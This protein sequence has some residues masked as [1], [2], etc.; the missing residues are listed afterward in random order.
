MKH[1]TASLIAT[2]LMALWSAL[3][4]GAPLTLQECLK[5]AREA[6]PTLRSGAWD[7]RKAQQVIRQ[8]AAAEYPRI[9]AQL[10]YTMQL[11]PQAVKIGGFTAETQEPDFAFGGVAASYT[12][13]DFGRRAARTNGARASAEA[14]SQQYLA[15]RDDIALQ[16]IEAYYR[17]LE[18]EQLVVAAG[19]EVTRIEEHRRITQVLYEEGVVTRNDVLQA[20]VRLA[21]ARQRRLSA[22]NVRDNA[23][24][25]L[26]FLTGS[27]AERR[28]EL[29]DQS[30][31]AL[32]PPENAEI[33]AD[34]GARHDLQALRHTLQVR[35]FEVSENREN[36][37]PE[38]YTRLALEYVQN[39]NVREQAIM[40]ATI[41]FR[42]NLFDGYAADA[43]RAGALLARSRQQDIIR[44]AELQA[45]LEVDTARNDLAVAR[46]QI[47]VAERAIQQ[48]EENLRINRERYRERV[49]TASEVL[50]AQTLLTQARTDFY[51]ARYAFQTA[52]A[53]LQRAAG[54]L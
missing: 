20:D 50:D 7:I 27:P 18:S 24:L 54:T 16:V 45:R 19:D 13:Y 28:A 1:L 23:W 8:T 2:M 40:S 49:G 26:N 12:F 47:V 10:G 14:V 15:R 43:A 3:S 6:N 9:D 5:Q 41:G 34:I 4:W 42:I 11:D 36:Y 33:Q 38:L 31:T 22:N 37:L 39:A 44:L 30:P 35:E 48:G 17:I 53:R 52:G 32:Q 46:Q 21:G 51:R 25:L 29:Q